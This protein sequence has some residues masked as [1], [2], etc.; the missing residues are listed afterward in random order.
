[1]AEGYYVAA[2]MR[3]PEDDADKEHKRVSKIITAA[4]RRCDHVSTI[5]SWTKCVDSWLIDW[6]LLFYRTAPGRKLYAAY[7]KSGGKHVCN[8]Q[9]ID[10]LAVAAGLALTVD[11]EGNPL[12]T[13]TD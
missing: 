10:A 4:V 8:I 6:D 9:E 7:R 2:K 1:M 3:Q 5:C 13:S 12:N 11:H